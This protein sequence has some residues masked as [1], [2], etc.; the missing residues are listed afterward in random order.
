MRKLTYTKAE[1]RKEGRV[2]A[3]YY[4]RE[5]LMPEYIKKRYEAFCEKVKVYD[6]EK[7]GG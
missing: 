3:L 6:R 1:L 4:G 7:V 2:F 5:E